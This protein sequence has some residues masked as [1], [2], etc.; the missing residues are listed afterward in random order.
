MGIIYGLINIFVANWFFSSAK[1]VKKPGIKWAAIG[2]VTFLL[3]IFSG[4][5]VVREIQTSIQSS[6]VEKLVEKGYVA[7]KKSNQNMYRQTKSKEITFLAV[8]ND[9][10]PLVLAMS[11]IVFIRAKFI[12]GIGVIESMKKRA[13]QDKSLDI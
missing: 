5:I 9:L 7:S 13:V 12:L 3:F 8:F 11:V 4:N 2:G 10:F 6:N 1:S